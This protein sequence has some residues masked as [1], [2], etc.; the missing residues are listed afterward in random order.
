MHLPE[1]SIKKEE[2][3]IETQLLTLSQNFNVGIN[4]LKAEHLFR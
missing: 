1:L 2:V 4:N 3:L